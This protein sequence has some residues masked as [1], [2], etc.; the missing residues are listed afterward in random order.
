MCLEPV[1]HIGVSGHS[2]CNRL[3]IAHGSNTLINS[4]GNHHITS[5][6]QDKK[7]KEQLRFAH[8]FKRFKIHESS[9]KMEEALVASDAIHKRLIAFSNVSGEPPSTFCFIEVALRE[10]VFNRSTFLYFHIVRKYCT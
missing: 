8:Y 9:R 5:A 3:I 4:S 10:L 1:S 2:A 6:A 7:L